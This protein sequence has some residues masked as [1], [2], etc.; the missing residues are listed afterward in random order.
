MLEADMNTEELY[1]DTYILNRI[2]ISCRKGDICRHIWE[3]LSK[4]KEAENNG[5]DK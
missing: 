1:A 3:K 2:I 4:K 5:T